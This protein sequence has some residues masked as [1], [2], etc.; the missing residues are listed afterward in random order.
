M[1]FAKYIIFVGTA[2][3]ATAALSFELPDKLELLSN[4]EI[5]SKF[6]KGQ[7]EE[8]NRDLQAVKPGNP[9]YINSRI[10]LL[11]TREGQSKANSYLRSLPTNVNL[12]SD[13]ERV[14]AAS[15]LLG[16][17]SADFVKVHDLLS[18]TSQNFIVEHARKI[19]FSYLDQIEGR[20]FDAIKRRIIGFVEIPDIA[21]LVEVFSIAAQEKNSEQI[22]T[23]F[24]KYINQVPDGDSAKYTLL[25]LRQVAISKYEEMEKIT[26]L[27]KEA[28]DLCKYDQ[29]NALFYAG[30]LVYNKNFDEAEKILTEQV[31]NNEYYSPYFDLFLSQIYFAK[32]DA[33][34]GNI[35][36]TKAIANRAYFPDWMR[37]Q[38]DSL[39]VDEQ[40]FGNLIFFGML[41]LALA[42][43]FA[44]MKK[45]RKE[46][47]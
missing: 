14:I 15:Y 8:L 11:S 37:A 22:L 33:E 45:N 44:R 47:L 23:P 20:Q 40:K 1:A 26:K 28:Y 30:L 2:I 38:V 39:G 42:F 24:F 32:N 16:T 29:S 25:A 35:Y 18:F 43:L 5:Y 9:D 4:N 21:H 7:F 3:L 31:Q 10:W 36:K 41:G 46:S 19:T 6:C 17:H 34:K 12:I 13:D 27:A